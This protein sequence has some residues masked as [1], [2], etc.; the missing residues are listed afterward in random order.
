MMI[1]LGMIWEK[2]Y[3]EVI[4]TNDPSPRGKGFDMIRFV[5]A[6]LSGDKVIRLSRTCFVIYLNRAPIYWFSKRKNG[7]ECSTFGS[8]FIA[9]K[10]C[11]EYVRRLRYKLRMMGI[12]VIGCLFLCGD[13][14]S[15]LLHL[16]TT[17]AITYH[18]FLHGFWAGRGT[19]T[20]TLKTKL[21]QQNAST[22][23]EVLYVILLDLS[24]VVYA[25]VRSRKIT[26]RTSSLVDAFC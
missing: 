1:S 3:G 9:M 10:Q 7:V 16:R 14:Q 4:P 21:L 15:V 19:G 13:N 24:K 20:A 17:T 2:H 12:P 8:E 26:Y 6:D 11:C 18:D 22:R 23:E 5:D 25:L